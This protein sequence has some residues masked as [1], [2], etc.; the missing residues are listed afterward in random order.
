MANLPDF[1]ATPPPPFDVGTTPSHP[2]TTFGASPPRPS[3]FATTDGDELHQLQ[4]KNKSKNTKKSTNT[5]VNRLQRW[6]EHKGITGTLLDL[7]EQQLDET[8]QQFYTEL[9]K[10]DG[11]D[12]EP[13]SLR[14]I[15]ASLDRYFRENG[16]PYSLLKTK[17]LSVAVKCWTERPWSSVKLGGTNEKTKQML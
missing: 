8:L 12:Y 10:E 5:W 3:V 11:S 1:T 2:S 6:Q 17:L 15:L 4:D 14:V 9:W 16:V 13:D 7:N